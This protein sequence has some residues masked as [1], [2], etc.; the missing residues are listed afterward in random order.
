MLKVS[1]IIPVHND[2]DFLHSTLN[3]VISQT[4]SN[5]QIIVI[6]D[7]SA[8]SSVDIIKHYLKLDDR[9][10][11][12][13]NLASNGV[14]NA[15]N[16]GLAR[17]TGD[18]ITFID[19]DDQIKSKFIE[20]LLIGIEESNLNIS[21]FDYKSNAEICQYRSDFLKY[22]NK[23]QPICQAENIYK[24]SRYQLLYMIIHFNKVLSGSVN[25]KMFSRSIIKKYQVKFNSDIAVGEDFLFCFEYIE[26]VKYANF[27]NYFD[28]EYVSNQ[29]SVMRTRKKEGY[30]DL[31][32]LSEVKAMDLAKAK[33]SKKDMTLLTDLSARQ[34]LAAGVLFKKIQENDGMA[35]EKKWLRNNF[36]N[37]YISYMKS[38]LSK[39]ITKGLYTSLF[40]TPH[41]YKLVRKIWK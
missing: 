35:L 9:I 30:F 36:R 40:Y 34:A 41:L 33:L 20:H 17:A 19:G 6:N 27:I 5:L 16:E 3:S 28:Y 25:T 31:K 14:S 23:F 1:V 29:H 22:Q 4:Y 12:F 2:E 8:D 7:H 24:I 18:Y 21:A 38:S 32:W 15:R 37:N 13:N 10:E 11:F 39:W 26:H